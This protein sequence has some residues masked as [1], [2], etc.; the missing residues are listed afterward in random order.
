VTKAGKT[1]IF[2]NMNF[3]LPQVKKVRH[4]IKRGRDLRLQPIGSPMQDFR[5]ISID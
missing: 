4:K 5:L 3:I 1:R 2:K